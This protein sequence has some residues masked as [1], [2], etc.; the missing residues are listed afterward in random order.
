M[1]MSFPA[2]SSV[3]DGIDESLCSLTYVGIGDAVKGITERGQDTQLAKVD[4]KSAYQNVPTHPDDWWLMGMFSK[5]GL[6]VDTTLPF[7]LRSA[8]II[9][10]AALAGAAEW[11]TQ[12][13]GMGFVIHYVDDGWTGLGGVRLCNAA[14]VVTPGKTFMRR[15]FELKAKVRRGQRWCRLN[16]GFRSDILWWVTFLEAWNGV[17]VM[18]G[19]AQE[20]SA[21]HVWTD[22]SGSFGCGAWNPAT[23]EWLQLAWAALVRP[24]AADTQDGGIAWKELL[25]IVLACAS[26]GRQWKGGRLTVHCDNT[27]AMAVV[28]SRYSRVPEIMHLLCCLFFYTSTPRARGVGSTHTRG[29]ERVVRCYLPG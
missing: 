2:G 21:N 17:S 4:V 16:A 23:G 29:R 10:T 6:F 1:D 7:S 20:R 8:P 13:E 15:M 26:W 11:M 3:N 28:N 18:K 24:R 14:Q 25:P 27:A 9:F 12:R 22:A 19:R 5:E